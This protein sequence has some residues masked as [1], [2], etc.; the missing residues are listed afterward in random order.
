M[1]RILPKL[2]F[3]A[4]VIA[5]ALLAA[6]C[7]SSGDDSPSQTGIVTTPIDSRYLPVVISEDLAVGKQRFQV[8]LIDQQDGNTPVNG[9]KLH[10]KFY[11]L[12]ADGHTATAKF[13][14]DPTAVTITKSYT[15]THEDGTVETH[16]AGETGAY[17]TYVNFDTAGFW[18]VEVTGTLADGTSIIADGQEPV[19][20]YFEV[21]EKSYGLAVGDPA[22]A[23]TQT[24]IADVSDIRSIDTSQT[25]IPEEHNMTVAQAIT[26]G[27]PTVIAF[28]TPAFCVSQLCGPTKEI[29]DG[30][31]DKYKG[32]ANFLHIE[33]YDVDKVRA[34]ECTNLGDCVVQAMYD[35][36]LS[37]E[38]WVFIIDA[39]GKIAA[40]Y[41]GI[42]SEAEMEQGLQA[43]L[44][45]TP[46]AT[47][48]Y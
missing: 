11:L 40:K 39:Q 13:D 17:I 14:I 45:Q 5:V 3:P 43:V 2:W 4:A 19:R 35:F 7:G 12:N 22:P 18:G 8:G 23:S 34:G 37:G 48:I 6:A 28:A 26:S 46:A 36:K 38:P 41:D 42:V 33:P 16:Q 32:Q 47:A 9:A 21:S 1:P 31:Y 10:F 27:K 20:P 44:G 24:V 29:F 30:L 25:P 15:H